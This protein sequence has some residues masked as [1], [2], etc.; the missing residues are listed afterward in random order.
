MGCVHSSH[1]TDVFATAPRAHLVSMVGVDLSHVALV[2]SA[3]EHESADPHVLLIHPRGVPSRRCHSSTA[4]MPQKQPTHE[5][6]RPRLEVTSASENYT[7]GTDTSRYG[8]S[9]SCI[10]RY[11]LISTVQQPCRPDATRETRAQTPFHT[12]TNP[13]RRT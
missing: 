7:H 5:N 13:T 2:N 11:E 1:H 4:A 8:S 12:S 3:R 10:C 9:R 6:S